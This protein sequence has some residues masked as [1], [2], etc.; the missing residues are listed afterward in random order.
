[1]KNRL[2]FFL[3]IAVFAT[4]SLVFII[5]LWQETT[6]TRLTSAEKNLLSNLESIILAGDSHF[7]PLSY[8]D[9]EGQF[10][11]YEADLVKALELWLDIPVHYEQIS[12]GEAAEALAEIRSAAGYQFDPTLAP[13]FIDIVTGSDDNL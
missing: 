11:G 10:N 6:K 1:M 9:H 8:T 3:I 7:P 2:Y 12:W 5:Y 13:V 4:V